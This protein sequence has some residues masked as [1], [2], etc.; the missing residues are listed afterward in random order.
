MLFLK[1]LLFRFCNIFTLVHVLV[2]NIQA[3]DKKFPWK[4]QASI[5]YP[6]GKIH[7]SFK[8]FLLKY[9]TLAASQI[10]LKI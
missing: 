8:D 7:P 3:K 9:C 5:I 4:D 2:D 10:F 1:T 6:A